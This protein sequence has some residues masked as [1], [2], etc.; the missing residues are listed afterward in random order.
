MIHTKKQLQFY[1]AADRIMKGL[2]VEQSWK[3]KILVLLGLERYTSGGIIIEFQMRMRMLSYYQNKSN[4][5]II[6]K[7]LKIYN[8][9]QYDRLALKLGFSLSPDSFGYGLVIPH[10]GTIVVNGGCKV[11]NYC[12]LHTS[13]CIAGGG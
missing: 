8:K 12:V 5:G 7:I 6:D 9:F 11:G 10:Y 13:T 1:I 4:K 2:S 3:D